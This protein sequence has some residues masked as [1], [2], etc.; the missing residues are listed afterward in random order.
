V[1]ATS[2]SLL[3]QKL[4]QS[5]VEGFT[6]T[7][8]QQRTIL[9]ALHP[10]QPD[11][12]ETEIIALLTL[13][14]R[15]GQAQALLVEDRPS[16]REVTKQLERLSSSIGALDLHCRSYLDA[17]LREAQLGALHRIEAVVVRLALVSQGRLAAD[18]GERALLPGAPSDDWCEI[19]LFR[20]RA[21][22][23][24]EAA[25]HFVQRAAEIYQQATGRSP[26]RR[27]SRAVGA[28]GSFYSFA[29]AAIRPPRIIQPSPQGLESLIRRAL[30][31]LRPIPLRAS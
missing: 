10:I 18:D 7:D 20:A 27:N 19:D 9:D 15:H 6:Y 23:R 13:A 21:K 25:V 30:N 5:D 31:E 2:S 4:G 1:A 3:K 17:H 11:A 22:A 28:D 16:S 8:E 29:L 14:A 24:D 26:S 12:E